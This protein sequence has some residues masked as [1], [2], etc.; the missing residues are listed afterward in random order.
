MFRLNSLRLIFSIGLVLS[1]FSGF[2]QEEVAPVAD[3]NRVF[4]SV[5]EAQQNPEAV[6]HLQ[7]SKRKLDSVPPEIFQFKNL[8][9]LDLSRNKISQLP[10]EIGNLKN[11]E[12]LILNNNQLEA[13]PQEIAQLTKLKQL[14]L[15]R[16]LIQ[17]LPPGIG[18]LTELEYLEL[19]DNELKDVPDEISNLQN[20][21]VVELRGILFSEEQQ[22]RIDGLVP[23]TSKLYMSPS[24]AC[25]DQ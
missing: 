23:K 3:E 1:T 14:S 18:Q 13:L 12:K 5:Q 21:K 22:A 25:K 4:R 7:L 11:L 15:N 9:V 24:C 17:E 8:R 20:L 10:A 16:N 6:F 19:W 2:S